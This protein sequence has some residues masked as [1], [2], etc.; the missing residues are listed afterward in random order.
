MENR[1]ESNTDDL[2]RSLD[3]STWVIFGGRPSEP[4]QPL[5]VP[6]VLAS[7]FRLPGE[8]YYSR[9]EGTQTQDAFETLMGGLEGG[10]SLAFASGMAAVACL[11][12][13]LPVG[14]TIVI[15]ADPYHAV[16]GLAL[17]G[18]R[19]GRWTV[20]MLDLADTAAWVAAAGEADLLWLESPANPL[21]TVADLPAICGAARR[22]G[23]LIAVDSTFAT[24]LVQR[25]LDLG[26]DV[27]MH[28][29]TKFI[30]GH[31]DLLAGV[32]SVRSDGLY[33]ELW[34][35]RLLN[36]G[37][38][39]ALEAY[40][41]IRGARTLALRMDK[42]MANAEVLAERLAAHPEVSRVRYPGL[43]SHDTH[44]NA[45]SF[46]CGFGAMMSFEVAGTPER[47][48]A[49]VQAAR[50][51]NHA[52]SLGGVESTMERRAALAGQQRIPPTLVRL[53]VGCEHVEDLWRDLDQAL[54][55]TA[56]P[57]DPR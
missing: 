4:G 29:A 50:V 36:G 27:V 24:P 7:N 38:I 28:S 34:Q 18:E 52:T 44:A 6:P 31:S 25:P 14:S 35:R 20:R 15:P 45:A 41:A 22:P 10:R 9:T 5:N 42:A 57:A 33:E 46:M 47:A 1:S 49:F 2:W 12:H 21:L 43:A 39:G 48:A 13:G 3:P 11:F 40:L 32:L 8:R 56:R 51:I 30:G 26:A 37:T 17:E 55:L 53:S 16:E 19:Q 54:A 23:C